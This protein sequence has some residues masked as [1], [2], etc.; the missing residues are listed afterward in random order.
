MDLG[1]VDLLCIGIDAKE[2]GSTL[3]KLVCLLT[4]SL[5]VCLVVC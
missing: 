5:A 1:D 3:S 4:D 2:G